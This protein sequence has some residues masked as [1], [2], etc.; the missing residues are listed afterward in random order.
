[1]ER[2][3]EGTGTSMADAARSQGGTAGGPDRTGQPGV[4]SALGRDRTRDG[5]LPPDLATNRLGGGASAGQTT[6]GSSTEGGPQKVVEQA[7]QAAEPVVG[8]A[9]EKAGQLLD[10]VT[11]QASSRLGGQIGRGSELLS[12][13]SHAVH[14]MSDQLR[15]QDQ[16]MLAGVADQAAVRVQRAANYLR[17]KDVDQLVA[18]TERFARRQPVVFLGGAFVVGLLAARFLKSSGS[19]GGQGMQS[20]Y[21][22]GGGTQAVGQPG[23]WYAPG[24]SPHAPTPRLPITDRTPGYGPAV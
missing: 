13:M 19:G 12:T 22:Q 14:S 4:E 11:T 20:Q 15:E 17:G 18:E 8:Q 2:S 21:G 9:Q 7:R 3:S 1:M 5:D 24:S 16:P 23:Q 10:Q 6:G